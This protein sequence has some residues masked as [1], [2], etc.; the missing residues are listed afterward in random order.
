[1]S[2]HI[3]ADMGTATI[4][5]HD[6]EEDK[7]FYRVYPP[8]GTPVDD[9]P[10]AQRQKFIA[11][12]MELAEHHASDFFNAVYELSRESKRLRRVCPIC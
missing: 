10:V 6:I 8:T 4:W 12:F 3:Q 7:N 9:Y 5:L 11:A 1:M 2:T